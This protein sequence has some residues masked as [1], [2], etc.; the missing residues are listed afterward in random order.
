MAEEFYDAVAEA[1]KKITDR[2]KPAGDKAREASD[3]GKLK[4]VSEKSLQ[5]YDGYGFELDKGQ[6][7]RYELTHGPQVIDTAYFVRSRPTEEWADPWHTGLFGALIL[8]EGMHYIS[9]TPFNRPLLTII[10]DTVD[11]ANLTK[12]YGKAAGHSFIFPSGRCTEG[13]W[14]QAYGVVNANSC[15]SN[16]YKGLIEVAGEEAARATQIPQAFMH[17][18]CL[19]YDKVPTNKSYYSGRGGAL[20][21]GDY[22]E[23]LAHQDLYVSVSMCPV[24]DQHDMSSYENFT[25]YPLKVQ[26][27]E[28]K[29]GPLETAPDPELKSTEA[30]DY[31]KAGRPGMVTGKTV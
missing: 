17:F 13:M 24:G 8:H 12:K 27:Y 15:N 23:L 11:Y 29:D 2:F 18:Q 1:K 14:E 4:L 5:P 31:I 22:V 16:L 3:N 28:G 30:V 20:K 19:A 9:N 6:V 25:C 10:K 7:I 26:I 21:V